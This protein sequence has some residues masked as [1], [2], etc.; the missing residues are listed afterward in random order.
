MGHHAL[1]SQ[2]NEAVSGA[3]KWRGSSFDD[4]GSGE[5][6]LPPVDGGIGW[7]SQS[8]AGELALVMQIGES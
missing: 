8:I 4:I 6:P 7:S 1:T 3:V 5:W 2:H